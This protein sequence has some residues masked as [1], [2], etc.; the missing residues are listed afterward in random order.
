MEASYLLVSQI[1]TN[2]VERGLTHDI[3]GVTS[4]QMVSSF[5]PR[6]IPED[7][8]AADQGLGKQ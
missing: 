6:I 1:P 7:Q 5:R 4:K 8:T 2:T 3:E